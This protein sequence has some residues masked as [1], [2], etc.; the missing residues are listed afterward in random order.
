MI[1]ERDFLSALYHSVLR[2]FVS[3]LSVFTLSCIQTRVLIK[4]VWFGSIFLV[5]FSAATGE[6]LSVEKAAGCPTVT[7]PKQ[8]VWGSPHS[9]PGC[10][11]T[12]SNS[13][14][15]WR[16]LRY[17]LGYLPRSAWSSHSYH[18]MPRVLSYVRS[19]IPTLTTAWKSLPTLFLH[20]TDSCSFIRS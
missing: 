6:P 20:H 8:S 16:L 13:L 2:A 9:S 1:C 5:S 4:F 15:G 7:L 18:P 12:K 19:F 14:R 17:G 11:V 3:E 10:L